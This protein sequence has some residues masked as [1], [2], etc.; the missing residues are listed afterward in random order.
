MR[1]H[2]WENH[3]VTEINGAGVQTEV[4]QECKVCGDMRNQWEGPYR[5]H[6]P[7]QISMP[8]PKNGF[9]EPYNPDKSSTP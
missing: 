3:S 1:R 2:K 5:K 9:G 4:W 8:M 7:D 6:C